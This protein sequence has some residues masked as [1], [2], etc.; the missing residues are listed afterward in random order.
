MR[1]T[2]AVSLCIGLAGCAASNADRPTGGPVEAPCWAWLSVVVPAGWWSTPECGPNGVTYREQGAGQFGGEIRIQAL[3]TA[4]LGSCE[5]AVKASAGGLQLQGLS[6]IDAAPRPEANATASR[7]FEASR[8]G[9]PM[10]GKIAARRSDLNGLGFCFYGVWPAGR[11]EQ[12]LRDF[13]LML[14]TAKIA[15]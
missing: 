1:L 14:D 2:I 7:R 9:R 12:S 11:D 10:R 3:E 8:F 15:K 6:F 4:D 13:Q 5:A